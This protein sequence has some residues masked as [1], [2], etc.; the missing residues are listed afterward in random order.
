[1]EL[2]D[3]Y[4]HIHIAT[5]HRPFLRFALEGVAYQ[6]AVL[7]FDCL[8]QHA[9]LRI[10]LTN[11]SFPSEAEG[12]PHIELPRRL[13]GS[14]QIRTGVGSSQRVVTQPLRAHRVGYQS[15]QESPIAQTASCLSE[16]DF[17]LHPNVGMD[18]PEQSL[19]IQ[20]HL[21]I[22]GRRVP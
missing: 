1:M 19:T 11:C 5:H 10:A 4:F 17:R 14:S 22:R 7:P 16:N 9:L 18:T 20:W 21:S 12:N 15:A 3:A 6:Y 2:K 13:A 8:W